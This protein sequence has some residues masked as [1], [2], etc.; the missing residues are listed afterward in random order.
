M[1]ALTQI[2]RGSN[3]R[4]ETVNNKRVTAFLKERAEELGCETY[5]DKG[6]NLIIRKKATPGR[7]IPFSLTSRLRGQARDL[8]P[9]THGYGMP[10]GRQRGH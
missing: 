2:P 10:E 3:K 4:G 9:G 7:R 8:L 1:L 6:E 5:I